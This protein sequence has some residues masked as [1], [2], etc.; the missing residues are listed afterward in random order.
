MPLSSENRQADA[1]PLASSRQ[2]LIADAR[3]ELRDALQASEEATLS[4]IEA[5][6]TLQAACEREKAPALLGEAIARQVSR[7]Y[8][9]CGFQDILGQRLR[10]ALHHLDR[11]EEHS[12]PA[13]PF[14]KDEAKAGEASLLNGPALVGLAP[15]QKEIDQLFGE[16]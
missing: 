8:E 13:T 6:G 12:A 15:S 7:I 9:Q 3:A 5:A 2:D 4:I 10:K 16:S 11:L 1:P 14:L